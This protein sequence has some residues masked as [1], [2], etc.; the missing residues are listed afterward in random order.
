MT[1]A[2]RMAFLILAE[3]MYRDIRASDCTLLCVGVSG[4]RS[5]PSI[6]TRSL[7]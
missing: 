3:F 1:Q 4:N 5:L 7:R 6:P 2:V